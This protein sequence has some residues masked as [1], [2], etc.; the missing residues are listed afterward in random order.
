MRYLGYYAILPFTFI[1]CSYKHVQNIITKPINNKDKILQRDI[2]YFFM[3]LIKRAMID[4][5]V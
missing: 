3:Y 5:S 1:Y 4:Q 2:N